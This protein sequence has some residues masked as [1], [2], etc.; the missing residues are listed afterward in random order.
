MR[1]SCA[2][3]LILLGWSRLVLGQTHNGQDFKEPPGDS[4]VSYSCNK[5]AM[6]SPAFPNATSN[7]C[8]QWTNT[9]TF[10]AVWTKKR[11]TGGGVEECC[12]SEERKGT[13]DC[14]CDASSTDG[15]YCDR[16]TCQ[17]SGWPGTAATAHLSSSDNS[18]SGTSVRPGLHSALTSFI[19]LLI[20]RGH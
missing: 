1:P 20:A 15:Q 9:I 4:S 12:E 6:L 2:C 13:E 18:S 10:N 16:H 5:R 17:R 3:T 11:T 19:L 8:E 7:F 14:T